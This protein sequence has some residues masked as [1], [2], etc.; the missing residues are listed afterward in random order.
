MKKL[1]AAITLT[2]ATL[3]P[4]PADAYQTGCSTGA[5]GNN[6]WVHCSGGNTQYRVRA[7]CSNGTY[8]YGWWRTPGT[9]ASS[10][11]CSGGSVVNFAKQDRGY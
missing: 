4:T 10:A 11:Y 7:Y 9:Y 2:A 3:T 1:I 5:S 8:A 6:A